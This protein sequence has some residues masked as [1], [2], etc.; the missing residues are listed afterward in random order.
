MAV[1]L[2]PHQRAMLQLLPDGLAWDKRPSSVSC[3]FVPG[4]QSFHG[5][6]FPGPGNQMLAER[7]P[8]SSRLLLEDW[9]RYL[10]LPECDMTGRNHSGASALCRE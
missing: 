1:T 8:D 6:V 10:G 4:P 9:E 5:S 3:G 7:F 2:P